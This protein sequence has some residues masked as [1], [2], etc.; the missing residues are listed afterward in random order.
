MRKR[1]KI[2]ASN[3]LRL[4]V[5]K[6]SKNI[7]ACMVQYDV[8]GDVVK[9]SSHSQNLKKFGWVYSTKNI[10]AA[11]LVG[12][13]LG[14]RAKN[15]KLD[16]LKEIGQ[17]K[18]STDLLKYFTTDDVIILLNELIFENL[19]DKQKRIIADELIAYVAYNLETGVVKIDK[20][21]V[22]LHSGILKR[23]GNDDVLNTLQL[24]EDLFAQAAEAAA[25]AA[26][27]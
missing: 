26:S 16:S 7:Q 21:N 6:S 17:V 27:N 11:Y 1:M 2:L 14:K 24:V 25:E 13:L 4:V 20:P 5:R 15:A 23:Y 18:K 10:P 19:D 3:K 9:V 22:K 8:K 12:Y